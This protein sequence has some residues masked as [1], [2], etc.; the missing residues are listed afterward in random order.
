MDTQLKKGVL[1]M[2][3]LHFLSKK[4]YY[5][6]E[7]NKALNGVI[8]TNESTSYAIFKK[9]IIKEY[10]EYYVEESQNGPSRKYYKIT[11]DGF[12]E[13]QKNKAE[14]DEFH[15]VINNLLNQ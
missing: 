10:A 14:W 11:K 1:E 2:L 13:L 6:Y 5:A 12:A 3:V 8:Q 7:L 4:N 15:K 9:L